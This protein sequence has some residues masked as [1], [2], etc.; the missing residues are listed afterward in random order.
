MYRLK[1]FKPWLFM[2]VLAGIVIAIALLT[3]ENDSAMF[4]TIDESLNQTEEN[5]LVYFWQEGCHYCEEIEPVITDYQEEGARPLYVID[6]QA[7]EN[8]SAWYDWDQHHREKDQVIGEVV[9]GSIEYFE[10]PNIYLED[11]D[12]QWEIETIGDE[13]KAVHQT[14]LYDKNPTTI[15]EINI[16]ATPALLTVEQGEP[17]ALVVGVDRVTEQLTQAKE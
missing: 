10:D 6:M 8:L 13:V 17:K 12:I 5:Y 16:P 4:I 3:A 11:P 9:D 14:A 2:S 7:E 1:R 15:A